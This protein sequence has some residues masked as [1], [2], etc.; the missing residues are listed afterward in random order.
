M[1]TERI[2]FISVGQ[3]AEDLGVQAWRIA[4]L[5]ELGVIPEPPRLSGR[6]IIP[7][8][9]IPAVISALRDRQWLPADGGPVL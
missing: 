8:A 9:V 6:R 1:H 3:L 7:T 2:D 5:F 4:R